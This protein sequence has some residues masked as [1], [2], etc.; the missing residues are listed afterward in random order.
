VPQLASPDAR[1]SQ[2][3]DPLTVVLVNDFATIAGGTDQV[4][5]GEAA[6]LAQRGHRVTLVSGSGKPDPQLLVA[7][8]EVLSTEQPTTL[9][10]PN[11]VRA[12]TRGL[13][14]QPAGALV[15]QVLADANP[16]STVVHVHGFTKVLSPSVVRAAVKSGI[17]TVATLH[18]YFVAC[19]N[20]GLFNYQTNEI[21]RL[22]PMSLTCVAT[23]C[24]ARAYSHKLWRVGRQAA[25]RRFGLMPSGISQV[26]V[27]SESA[28]EIVKQFLPSEVSMAIV[29]NPVSV[30]QLPP[31]DV[32]DNQPFVM[33]GRLERD[34]GAMLL[35]Q[36]GQAAGLRVVFVGQGTEERAIKQAN[37]AAEITGWLEPEQVRTIVRGARA[38]VN[39]SLIYETQGLTLLEAAAE[40]VPAIVSDTSVARD[41]VEPNL[42]GL[43]FKSGDIDDLRHK[44]IQLHTDPDLAARMG[45][46]A[47]ARFWAQPP[48]LSTHLDQLESIYRDA[49]RR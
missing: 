2:L 34:K 10:D 9:S 16:A 3:A 41:A 46:A 12:A 18:D 29:S 30:F 7:G 4:A 42:T 17:P 5:L 15:R 33:V 13:W 19:P 26:I 40:G 1:P 32:A 31:A 21:C 37:P 44:L 25:Q 47:Y 38:V 24:D 14:N 28:A 8:V 22:D 20:G 45:A 39:A 49:L 36:A 23:H 11:R 27:P 43:W 35:A 6:G 48:D